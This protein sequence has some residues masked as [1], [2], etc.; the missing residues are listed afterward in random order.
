VRITVL[1]SGSLDRLCPRSNPSQQAFAQGSVRKARVTV[2]G[3]GF[4]TPLARRPEKEQEVVLL[5]GSGQ[6]KR[7][8]T[9]QMPMRQTGDI[10]MRRFSRSRSVRANGESQDPL[11]AFECE[12]KGVAD[13]CR[14][15]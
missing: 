13:L 7:D 15:V 5:V 1:A 12:E 6:K 4:G 3:V 10:R 14:N 8:A 2:P 9:A 11:G